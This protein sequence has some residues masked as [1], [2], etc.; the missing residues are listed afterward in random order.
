MARNPKAV[1]ESTQEESVMMIKTGLLAIILAGLLVGCA[2]T[3]GDKELLTIRLKAGAQNAGAIAQVSLIGRGDVTDITYLISGVPAGVSRPLQLY[4]F[5]YSG[6]CAELSVE[7]AYSMNNTTQ[8][9]PT[10]SGWT[11]SREVPVALSDLRSEPH[12]LMVRTSPADGN[13]DIFCG[14]ISK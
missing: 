2:G 13:I 8:T 14:G 3:A 12:A 11:L 1:T 5:I 7:P 6:T 4:T 10:T 9:T